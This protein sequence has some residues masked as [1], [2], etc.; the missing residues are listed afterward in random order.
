MKVIKQCVG[1]DVSK[2]SLDCCMGSLNDDQQETFSKTKKFL[3]NEAGFHQLLKWV[4]SERRSS[5][6][7]VME[8]TG[9]YYENLAYWLHDHDEKLSVLLPNKVKHYAKSLNIKTKTDSKDARVLSQLGL[10][11]RVE[12][13][14]VPSKIMREIK[15][16]SREYRETKVK[17][18]QIKNQVHAKNHSYCCPSS[19][20]KRLKRQV[21]LLES[22]LLEVEAELRIMAM[23]DSQLYD[24]ISRLCTIPGISFITVICILAETNAFA[25]VTNAKQLV[26]YAGFDIQHNQSGLKE[27]KSK[28]SK[29]GNSFIRHALYMPSLCASRHNPVMKEFYS[30]L[31]DRK[32]AKKIAVTA[33][34]RKLLILTYILWKNN[35]EFKPDY[36]HDQKLSI[37]VK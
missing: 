29:K 35:D 3:N 16:L 26:S 21:A 22:Q 11:R 4:N 13:W 15:F 25:L 5:V 7:F 17:L 10:E 31:S 12:H 14:Q 19:T 9:V 30:Q 2:D 18:V 36:G 20:E 8:A 24:K 37:L 33:V 27:G 23:S 28:I 34:A 32:P 6:V 1:I